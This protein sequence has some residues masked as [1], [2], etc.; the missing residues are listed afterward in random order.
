MGLKKFKKEEVMDES[1]NFTS[2]QSSPFETQSFSTFEGQHSNFSTPSSSRVHTPTLE[3]SRSARLASLSRKRSQLIYNNNSSSNLLIKDEDKEITSAGLRIDTGVRK[4]SDSTSPSMKSSQNGGAFNASHVRKR[5]SRG[6]R[7]GLHTPMNDSG[8]STPIRGISSAY[9]GQKLQSLADSL[10]DRL[11]DQSKKTGWTGDWARQL[12]Q[13]GLWVEEHLEQEW[14]LRKDAI[15]GI[16]NMW[17]LLSSVS[18]FNPVCAASFVLKGKIELKSL[19]EIAKR[20]V[21]IFPKYRQILTNT[22]RKFHGSTFVDD[23]N[24]DVKRH[25]SI[26]SLPQHAGRKELDAFTA[27]FIARDWDFTKPLWEMA[28]IDNFKE[29]GNEEGSALITR[30]HHSM[31]DGQ[32]FVMSQLYVSSF[33]PE[34]E[35]MLTEGKATI[36][37]ARRGKARPSKLHKSLKP[38]DP[39]RHM[40]VLQLIMFGL[41]WAIWSIGNLIDAFNA[42]IQLFTFSTQY[43]LYGWRPLQLT[44]DYA[45]PRVSKREFATS[46]RMP[47]SD[48]RKMQ[49]A[50][51]GPVPGGWIDRALGRKERSWFGHLTLNDI[52]CTIIADV[53]SDERDHQELV[54]APTLRVRIQRF[55]N[56]ILPQRLALMI[57]ISIRPVANWD[58]RNWSTGSLVFL[59]L[60]DSGSS[61]QHGLPL[62]AKP[63]H[64][65]LHD[66]SSRLRVLKSGLLPTIFFWAVQITGQAPLLFPSMLWVPFRP[67]VKY[68]VD[69]LLEAFSAVVTNVPGPQSKDG[70]EFADKKVTRWACAPPQAGKGTLGIGIITYADGIC[71]TIAADNVEGAPSDGVTRRVAQKFATRWAQYCQVA[72]DILERS[73]SNKS[74][75]KKA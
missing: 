6:F 54:P 13:R 65:R 68:G 70:I 47:M 48:V 58:M 43:I 21:E 64:A 41:F 60:P 18:A 9:L 44:S 23:P 14:E 56:K 26:Y 72:D 55:A 32:G 37:A 40:I 49:K 42:I 24:W 61:K 3:G 17:I 53:L 12:I 20:Q 39:Y 73:S 71:I 52:L 2:N 5:S 7:S 25:I 75:Q 62:G 28:V 34:L 10:E 57:P 19:E 69:L 29:A 46:E 11:E 67:F 50:F 27:E 63:M 66:V 33:G 22:G 4:M 30:G 36:Q 38:L 16:D 59:P 35:R 51:S 15:G 31:A 1:Q 8:T 45:G 74:N